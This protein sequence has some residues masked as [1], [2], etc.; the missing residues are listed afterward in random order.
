M[1]SRH[2]LELDGHASFLTGETVADGD[3]NRL[4]LDFDSELTAR[5]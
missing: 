3:P 4:P 5:A 1:P 2:V